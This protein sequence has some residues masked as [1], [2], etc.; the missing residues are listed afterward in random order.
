MEREGR[1]RYYRLASAA[2]AEVIENL[3]QLTER[4]VPLSLKNSQKS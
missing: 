2:V 4:P 3:A 1:H